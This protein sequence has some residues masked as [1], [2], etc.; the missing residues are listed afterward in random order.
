MRSSFFYRWTAFSFAAMACSL[1]L[2]QPASAPLN[3]SDRAK[4]SEELDQNLATLRSDLQVLSTRLDEAFSET[5]SALQEQLMLNTKRYE[6]R[7]VRTSTDEVKQATQESLDSTRNALVR[8]FDARHVASRKKIKSIAASLEQDWA[9]LSSAD[10]DDQSQI[11][12]ELALRQRE[13]FAEYDR[14]RSSYQQRII[15]LHQN[16]V[17]IE[18][19]VR[20][21]PWQWTEEAVAE[22]SDFRRRYESDAAS[23]RDCYREAIEN[24]RIEID[25]L[26][27]I[28]SR[29]EKPIRDQLVELADVM[30]MQQNDLFEELQEFGKETIYKLGRF[31]SYYSSQR[32]RASGVPDERIRSEAALVATSICGLRGQLFADYQAYHE[33]LRRQIQFAQSRSAQTADEPVGESPPRS[34]TRLRGRLDRVGRLLK[35]ARQD[36]ERALVGEIE[37]RLSRGTSADAGSPDTLRA[38]VSELQ[39]TLD[40]VRAAVTSVAE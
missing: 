35:D 5:R 8:I 19:R 14:L 38:E 4:L 36:Y 28:D 34:V 1:G 15:R 20:V 24:F 29:I 11:V 2:A 39:A 12:D 25:R 37:H 18:N 33:T 17:S 27:R 6:A 32:A 30:S 22:R 40:Q 23:L 26:R 21:S 31:A 13:W 7:R 3:Q 9:R 16:M 10:H